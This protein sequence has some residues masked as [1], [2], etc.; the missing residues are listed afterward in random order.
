MGMINNPN[1]FDQVWMIHKA[2]DSYLIPSMT[3]WAAFSL[4][5]FDGNIAAFKLSSKD[6]S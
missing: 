6:I 1:D 3:V 4:E 5:D 2:C